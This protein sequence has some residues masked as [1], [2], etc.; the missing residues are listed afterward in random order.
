MTTDYPRPS[1]WIA[2]TIEAGATFKR[3]LN[4]KDSTGAVVDL[5]GYSVRGML[6]RNYSDAAPAL[7]M[8]SFITIAS[9]A[10]GGIINWVIPAA[11][12]AGL[13][14][15]YVFDLEL[16]SGGGEVTRI[17]QGEVQVIPEATK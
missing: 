13:G 17:L 10:T 5:T 15:K 3:T 16:V 11:S 1:N 14:G 4:Y 9:P 6:R 8:A 7:D 2:E 12:T